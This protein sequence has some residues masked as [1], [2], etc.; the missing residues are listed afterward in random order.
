MVDQPLRRQGA[1]GDAHAGAADAD[2]TARLAAQEVRALADSPTDSELA[3]GKALLKA[4]LFMAR[5]STLS[6][7]EQAAGQTLLFDRLFTSAELSEAIDAV[8][9]DDL[10]RV[11]ER[12]L[13]P[14][15]SAGAVLGP[16]RAL[17]AVEAFD[18]ALSA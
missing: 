4:S 8:T 6:R 17:G 1:D 2:E 12:L 3:R 10:R 13:E 18:R 15:R 7:A 16:K 14:R 9:R 5:E 11:G